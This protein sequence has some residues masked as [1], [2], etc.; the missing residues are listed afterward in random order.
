MTSIRKVGMG[1]GLGSRNL[2]RI[3]EITDVW[4]IFADGKWVGGQKI[5]FFC[6]RHNYM[7]TNIKSYFHK[8]ECF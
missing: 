5:V 7:T 2:A 3:Y 6:E 1:E 4:F 8:K